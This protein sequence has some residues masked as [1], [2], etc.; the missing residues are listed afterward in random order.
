L[1]VKEVYVFSRV[2]ARG[3][4]RSSVRSAFL[5]LTLVYFSKM[6]A[7]LNEAGNI[8]SHCIVNG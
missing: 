4:I 5:L 7:N 2:P 1:L 3:A 8:L 6:G